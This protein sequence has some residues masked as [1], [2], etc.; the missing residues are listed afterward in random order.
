MRENP[1]TYYDKTLPL[2]VTITWTKYLSPIFVI[3]EEEIYPP[4]EKLGVFLARYIDMSIVP[5]GKSFSNLHGE[6]QEE[7]Y[8]KVLIKRR[9]ED[10]ASSFDDKFL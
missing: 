10:F 8:A 9:R 4:N 6:T 1:D 7:R 2:F 5:L 3:V